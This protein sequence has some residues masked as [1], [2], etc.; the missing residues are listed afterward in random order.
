MRQRV[1]CETCGAIL[2]EGLELEAPSVIILRYN[3]TC[4]NC[5]KTLSF[6]VEKVRIL[7]YDEH[8]TRPKAEVSGAFD[9]RKSPEP[10][11]SRN[12]MTESEKC[13]AFADEKK[14]KDGVWFCLGCGSEGTSDANGSL[15]FLP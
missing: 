9:S 11:G 15:R 13:R 6:E 4:P 12:A 3:G 10:F 14:L 2:Y 8:L 5:Q 1:F 7:P